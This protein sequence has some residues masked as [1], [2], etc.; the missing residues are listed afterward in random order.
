MMSV[1]EFDAATRRA[2]RR[3]YFTRPYEGVGSKHKPR[4]NSYVVFWV[5]AF[6]LQS[7]KRTQPRN[8]PKRPF[9]S[10]SQPSLQLGQ[11]CWTV[12]HS[13]QVAS[14]SGVSRRG[15]PLPQAEQ[16]DIL[17]PHNC[18]CSH[19]YQPGPSWPGI[20]SKRPPHCWQVWVCSAASLGLAT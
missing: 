3:L 10:T 11:D 20:K 17:F 12:P 2:P 16:A 15:S 9:R 6:P 18:T 1:D 8:G 4:P 5:L 19:R 13:V 7:G 14:L